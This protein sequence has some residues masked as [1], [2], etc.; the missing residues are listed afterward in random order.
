V[1]ENTH[2]LKGQFIARD[3]RHT[4]EGPASGNLVADEESRMMSQAFSLDWHLDRL[5]LQGVV[6]RG[7][8]LCPGL[9]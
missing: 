8:G 6:P 1:P 3:E 2:A 9:V 4:P 7:A 5:V